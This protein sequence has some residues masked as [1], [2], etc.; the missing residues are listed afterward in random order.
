MLIESFFVG[1]SF[2]FIVGAIQS[3]IVSWFPKNERTKTYAISFTPFAIAAVLRLTVNLPIKSNDI[4]LIE[5]IESLYI[6]VLA[7]LS[8]YNVKDRP[9]VPPS[10]VASLP[11]SS[12]DI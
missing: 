9:R 6:M 3:S 4:G 11:Q 1:A 8:F 10:F 5:V 2:P 12:L 7:V